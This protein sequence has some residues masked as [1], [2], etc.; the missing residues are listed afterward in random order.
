MKKRILSML[1]ILAIAALP[2]IGSAASATAAQAPTAASGGCSSSKPFHP[3]CFK[4]A[5]DKVDRTNKYYALG[6]YSGG[7]SGTL[8]I[9]LEYKGNFKHNSTLCHINRT[10]R[11]STSSFS[12]SGGGNQSICAKI[13]FGGVPNGNAGPF[14]SCRVI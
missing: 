14:W 2:I 1:S 11:V 5:V 4:V 10:C 7:H 12:K 6:S 13:Q 8:Q 3:D 9:E